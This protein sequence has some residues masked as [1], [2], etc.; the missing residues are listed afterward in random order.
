MIIQIEA[1]RCRTDGSA[2]LRSSKT[3][4]YQGE[5]G[6]YGELASIQH[7]GESAKLEGFAD[8][9]DVFEAVSS[10]KA[11]FGVVPIENSVAGSIHQNYDLLVT[12]DLHIVGEI[13]LRVRH[14]LIVSPDAKRSR[15][16]DI[17]SHPQSLSQC[18]QWIRKNHPN[19]R[20]HEA[21]NNARAV[22]MVREMGNH[23]AAAIASEQAAE[24][25]GMHV[26]KAGIEDYDTNTTR[27][28]VLSAKVVK[29]DSSKAAVKTSVVF[30]LGNEPGSLFKAL[31]VFA[32][33]DI[34]LFRIESRPVKSR[35]FEYLFYVDFAGA[36]DDPVSKKAI[37]H[38]L[39]ITTFLRVL[40]SYYSA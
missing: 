8:F 20:T 27:F 14:C 11:A 36:L 33:R 23:H 2:H 16:D 1:P 26:R 21:S 7:F 6:A 38:L 29:P 13:F 5:P 39:E 12:N 25:F 17:Y 34:N 31:S 18:R 15:I 9:A 37:D 19:A 30:S 4:A 32:L 22:R 35:Q 28:L 40:G 3:V 10:G 24:F